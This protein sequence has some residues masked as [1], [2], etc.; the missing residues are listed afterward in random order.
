[1]LFFLCADGLDFQAIRREGLRAE[2][3][4]PLW[5]ALEDARAACAARILVVDPA[6]APDPARDAAAEQI[7]ISAI[8]PEA[9]VN[10]DPYLPPE[11]VTAAGG[12]VVRPGEAGPEVL[13]IF[14]RGVWDLPKGKRDPGETIEACALRE[15]REEVG[16]EDL[17]LGLPVGT[18][19]HGYPRGGGYHV[20]TTHWF[21]MRTS[22]T[23]FTPE[24]REGIEKVRWMP[25]REAARRI[26]YATLRAHMD[27]IEPQVRQAV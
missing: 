17:R 2:G 16:V 5:T 13:V 3:V 21:L 9:I 15:V 27:E 6:A 14:R 18:T 25:W 12:Y 20:K 23:H 26:G 10:L 7:R 1:M 8:P 4:V 24:A 22:E 19:L 11:A